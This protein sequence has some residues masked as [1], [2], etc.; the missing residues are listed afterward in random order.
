[1]PKLKIEGVGEYEVPIGTRLVNAL[2]DN[3]GKPLTVENPCTAAAGMPAAPP[4]GWNSWM[5]NRS[6]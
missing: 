2:E 1:M 6:E 5:E 3:G 4:A